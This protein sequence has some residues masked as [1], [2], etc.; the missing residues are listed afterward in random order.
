MTG[1]TSPGPERSFNSATLTSASGMGVGGSVGVGVGDGVSVSVGVAEG[2]AV[3]ASDVGVA[4]VVGASVWAGCVAESSGTMLGRAVASTAFTVEVGVVG[5]R[6]ANRITPP[7]AS[8]AS[9]MI[10][11]AQNSTARREWGA[12]SGGEVAKLDESS[13]ICAVDCSFTRI[14]G[15]TV[16]ALRCWSGLFVAATLIVAYSSGCSFGRGA[17]FADGGLAEGWPALRRE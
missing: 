10:G 3:G 16:S 1:Y 9:S 6:S 12:P 4:G 2:G 11:S 15:A 7:P 13:I 17:V 8:S 5:E 14:K